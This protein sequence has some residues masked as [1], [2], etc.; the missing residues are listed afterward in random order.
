MPEK[1]TYEELQRRIRSLEETELELKKAEEQLRD[2][3]HWRR[4]LVEES[5]D[6]IVILDQNGKVFEANKRYADML[7]YSMDDVRQ[8]HVWDWDTELSKEEILELARSVDDVG[9]RFETRHRRKDGT[10]IDVDLCNNGVVY[11]GQKYIFSISRDITERKRA[12]EERE[13]LIGELREALAEVKI[14]RGILPI[15]SFCKKVR[16]DEGFWEQVDVY[17]TKYTGADISHGICP[18]CL[19]EHYPDDA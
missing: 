11:R 6:G 2:E 15:C 4:V 14:L 3:I 12:A 5:R 7:G 13:R 19:K 8:L 16:D 1:P 18:D 10:L 9:H 17:I